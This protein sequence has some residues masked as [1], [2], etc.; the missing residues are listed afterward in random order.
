MTTE[1]TE[2]LNGFK[3]FSENPYLDSIRFLKEYIEVE[4]SKEAFFELGKALFFNEEYS[5]SIRYLEMSD[6]FRCDAYLGLDY[7]KKEEFKKAIGHFERFL[8]K[9]PNETVLS[10]LMLS[11]ERINRWEDA[12]G[13][14]EW[15]LEMNPKND[16]VKIRLIDYHFRLNQYEKSLAYIE[17]L[18]DERFRYKKAEAL[19]HLERY[20][21]VIDHL[22]N[23]KSVEAY[24]LLSQTYQRLDRPIK[25]IRYLFKS[26]G[27]DP[28]T[29]TLFEISDIYSKN[30]EYNM[31]NKV[32]KRIL[33]DD[34]HDERALEKTAENYLEIQKL[35]LAIT[36]S[37]ELLKVNENSSKAY[38]IMSDAQYILGD[39]EKSMDNIEKAIA[40]SPESA[41]LWIK[42]AWVHY[43]T[44][45]ERFK[46]AFEA[47]LRLD[48][49]NTENYITLIRKCIWEDELCEAYKYYE[50]LMLYNPAFEKSFEDIRK[51]CSW[52][53]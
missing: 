27:L 6:D 36:Y 10:Y 15:I 25:A 23:I 38:T 11:Y 21:E 30:R 42:K 32:L 19:F 16:S 18:D 5:E 22:K 26:Y 40:I 4:P 2:I 53:T 37:E 29:E 33:D 48:V 50:R 52:F 43:P 24:H 35:E 34:P 46:K 39:I 28:N 31:S 12:V 9:H 47:A 13:C 1:I 8:K 49:N 14:G 41:E 7:Y 51:D 45:F 3:E 20:D 44:D 17:E